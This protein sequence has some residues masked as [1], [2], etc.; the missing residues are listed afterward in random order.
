MGAN[1]GAQCY[2]ILQPLKVDDMGWGMGEPHAW[3]CAG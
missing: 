2:I 3:H 1:N